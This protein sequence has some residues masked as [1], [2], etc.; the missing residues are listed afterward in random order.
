VQGIDYAAKAAS[1]ADPDHLSTLAVPAKSAHLQAAA[2]YAQ[3]ATAAALAGRWEPAEPADGHEEAE[4]VRFTADVV[5][6][7]EF[8]NDV[9]VL[10]IERGWEPFKG[11]WALPGGHVDP[12]E[13]AEHAA[14]RELA[15]ETGIG[16]G[17]QLKQVG[18]YA[19]PGRD[20]RGRYVTFAYAGCVDHRIVPS[21]GDDAVRAQW[22]R[23]EEVLSERVR[24]AFD[25]AQIIHDALHAL[26]ARTTA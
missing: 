6:I 22:V 7:G 26:A 11:C 19:A 4:T 16:L 24:V 3:L 15:E 12:G 8:D 18:G 2:V 25:H 23:L 10:L 21:A 5:L 1:L 13:D 14:Y 17:P 20:P 9:W